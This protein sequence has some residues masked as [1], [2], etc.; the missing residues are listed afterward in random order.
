M[1]P[2]TR[3]LQSHLVSGMRAAFR[4][5]LACCR[6]CPD[7]LFSRRSP[8]C[9]NMH[10]RAQVE[11]MSV[12]P[13]L[14]HQVAKQHNMVLQLTAVGSMGRPL[15][16]QLQMVAIFVERVQAMVSHYGWTFATW[17]RVGRLATYAYLLEA[18]GTLFSMVRASMLAWVALWLSVL[19]A[20]AGS[21]LQKVR[22]FGVLCTSCTRTYL[23]SP[24][25][26]ALQIHYCMR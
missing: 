8:V 15:W 24:C 18:A 3:C 4:A 5:S 20:T 12:E 16:H 6:R 11:F 17:A 23:R 7:A 26:S 22:V 19:C 1:R 9:F 21:G 13:K 10:S 25:G 2:D 14:C